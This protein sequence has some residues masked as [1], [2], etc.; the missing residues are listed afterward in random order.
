MK[1]AVAMSGS[2]QPS[3]NPRVCSCSEAALRSPRGRSDAVGA[4]KTGGFRRRSD[5][6]DQRQRKGIACID[7]LIDLAKAGAFKH[8]DDLLGSVLVRAL[9]PDRLA[10]LQRQIQA[11]GGDLDAL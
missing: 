10:V 11:R 5:G 1:V 6:F 3:L 9:G 7:P 4:S 2:R 8:R